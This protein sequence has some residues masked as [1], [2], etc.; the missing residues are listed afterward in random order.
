MPRLR[1]VFVILSLDVVGHGPNV[2][3]P[4]SA[5]KMV[6]DGAAAVRLSADLFVK[7]GRA[8]RQACSDLDW[9]GVKTLELQPRQT[10]GQPVQLFSLRVRLAAVTS[11]S[12]MHFCASCRMRLPPTQTAST[13]NPTRASRTA[14][15]SSSR[16]A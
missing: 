15:T 12:R 9:S 14:T 3:H 8:C 1:R 10:R 13:H 11:V 6:I 2:G 7:L 5:E 4:Q 16:M